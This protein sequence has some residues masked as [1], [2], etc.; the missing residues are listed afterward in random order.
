MITHREHAADDDVGGGERVTE[1]E[2]VPA[3]LTVERR[4]GGAEPLPLTG[5]VLV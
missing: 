4:G 2:L 3:E 5:A 1:Q